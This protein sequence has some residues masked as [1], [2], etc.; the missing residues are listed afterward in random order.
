MVRRQQPG[1]HRCLPVDG[2]QKGPE[3]AYR[4]RSDAQGLEHAQLGHR[5]SVFP[6]GLV[7]VDR[8]A[9]D[10]TILL[11]GNPA[12]RA[13]AVPPILRIFD[14]PALPPQPIPGEHAGPVRA[15]PLE[16][17]RDRLE[18]LVGLEEAERSRRLDRLGEGGGFVRERNLPAKTREPLA[19]A[20][21]ER[22]PSRP[23]GP[24]PLRP[25]PAPLRLGT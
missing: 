2:E 22:L 18:H 4:L 16:Y 12:F 19:E 3:I 7:T 11:V 8:K 15:D 17:R 14:L 20:S 25:A 21:V 1:L 24:P 9:L 23:P 5:R 10:R 13:G 6:A